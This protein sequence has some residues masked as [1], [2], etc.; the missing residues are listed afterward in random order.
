M[1]Y[2]YFCLSAHYRTQ[3]SFSW[4]SL[5]A[6]N[7]ALGRLYQTAFNWGPPTV[8]DKDFYQAFLDFVNDDLNLPR[9]LA[10]TWDLVKSDLEDGSKKATLLAFDQIFGL[11]IAEWQPELV[12]IPEYIAKLADDRA[13]A[14]K[15]KN[16]QLADQ[17]RADLLSEGYVVEDTR[18][19]PQIN[20]I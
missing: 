10:L 3:M 19:G 8:V 5:E 1:S 16:W 4:E 11:D 6:N 18:D 13:A 2:R 9:A 7:V 17:I 15:D 20:K 14:R 12:E